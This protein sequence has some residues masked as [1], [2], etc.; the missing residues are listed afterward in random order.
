MAPVSHHQTC[1]GRHTLLI[2]LDRS[3]VPDRLTL[4]NGR[5][6]GA[7]PFI[8]ICGPELRALRHTIHHHA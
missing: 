6:R 8:P 3:L 7:R 2:L 1:G 5:E 4:L